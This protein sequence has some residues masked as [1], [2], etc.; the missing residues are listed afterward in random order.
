MIIV[1]ADADDAANTAVIDRVTEMVE[2]GEGIVPT[3]DKWGRR[4]FAYEIDHKHEGVYTVLEITTDATD[5]ADVDR[6]LRLADDVVRHKL[7]RLPDAE[8]ER[9]GL[10]AS[11]D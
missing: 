5:L 10:L 2:A 4:R 1:D 8:A 6:F 7:I 3:V 9:R 11:A